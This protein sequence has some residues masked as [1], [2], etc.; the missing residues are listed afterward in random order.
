[1]D[2][3]LII[4]VVAG[5]YLIGAIPFGL[6]FSRMF[7]GIDVRSVGSGNIGATNV[8]RAGGKTA[9]FLTLLADGFKGALPVL[10]VQ[11]F[12]SAEYLL[13]AAGAAAVIGHNFP[14]YLRFKGGKGVATGFGVIL[15]VS[16]LIGVLCLLTWLGAALLWKYSSLAALTAYVA[17]PVLTFSLM[18]HSKPLGALSLFIAG[19]IYI[20]HRENIQRLVA[21]KEP[22]IGEK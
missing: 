4:L 16:P 21:G 12:F 5:A 20:R 18:P 13:A 19:L 2:I 17:Y 10:A 11:H 22:K 1:M 15:A 6:L 8:L 14:I 3:L 7:L 9:A